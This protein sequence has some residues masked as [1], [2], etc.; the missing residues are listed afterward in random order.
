MLPYFFR[1]Y[2]RLVDHY[3]IRDNQSSDGSLDILH[4]HPRVTVLPLHLDGESLVESAFAQVNQFW[5]P[6]RGKADWVAVCNV[7]EFFWHPELLW[8]LRACRARG[9]TWLRSSGYQMVS[10]AFPGPHDN[11]P[12][13]IRF[14]A[15]FEHYDKP[16]FFNPDAIEDSGFS[17][18]R[19]FASPTGRVV[20]PLRR[21][22]LL[23]HYKYI[24]IDYLVQRHAELNARLRTKDM[25]KAY[26]AQYD[27]QATLDL[28]A[29][30]KAQSVEAVPLSESRLARRWRRLRHVLQPIG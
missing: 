8:Y 4:R 10:E 11:L 30:Y 2:D 14:G 17:V 20:R 9:I 19:H 21:E 1:Y 12:E 29:Q 26:G 28:F 27:P 24:G 25:A 5:H 22:I 18:A 7:D 13:T 16:A 3:F 23:L 6:S 15:R